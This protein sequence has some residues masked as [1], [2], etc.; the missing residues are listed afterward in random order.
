[1]GDL[2]FLPVVGKQ[3][4]GPLEMLE[5]LITLLDGIVIY[6]APSEPEHLISRGNK[7][8]VSFAI[9]FKRSRVRVELV[10]ITLDN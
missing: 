7:S 4:A 8:P 2:H 5:Q 6:L 10:A 9:P 3:L 1:M